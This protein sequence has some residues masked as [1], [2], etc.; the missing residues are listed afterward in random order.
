MKLRLYAICGVG[1]LI[2]TF[3]CATRDER[4]VSNT[5]PS[6]AAVVRIDLVN[7]GRFTDFRRRDRRAQTR[8]GQTIS[9]PYTHLAIY[10]YQFV[11]PYYIRVPWG[12]GGSG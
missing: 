5:T 12:E 11:R 10:G 8:D 6:A 2:G 3:G 7:P 4:P 1:I 9:R